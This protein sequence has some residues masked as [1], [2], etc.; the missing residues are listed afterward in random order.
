MIFRQ[1]IMQKKIGNCS[2]DVNET[3]MKSA[4]P[5]TPHIN[6]LSDM[7]YSN[8]PNYKGFKIFPP[9]Y[10]FCTCIERTWLL[11]VVIGHF[12]Q[13]LNMIFIKELFSQ[14]SFIRI[15]NMLLISNEA[16]PWVGLV[17]S[18]GTERKILQYYMYSKLSWILYF[19]RYLILIR[20]FQWTKNILR[21]QRSLIQFVYIIYWTLIMQHDTCSHTRNPRSS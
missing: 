8:S 20:F 9:V 17:D 12:D 5:T 2:R 3:I 14:M 19:E 7:Q 13:L 11:L 1:Q 6:G 10:I 15:V 21:I 16:V 18:R 4:I